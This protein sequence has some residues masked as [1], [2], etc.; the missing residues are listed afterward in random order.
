MEAAR[1]PLAE[2]MLRLTSDIDQNA[3]V[4]LADGRDRPDVIIVD[5]RYGLVTVDIEVHGADPTAREPFARL[6]RKIAEL[7]RS[8]PVVERFR[9]HRLVLFGGYHGKLISRSEA[10]RPNALSLVDLDS[11]SWLSWLEQRPPDIHD[12]DELRSALVPA[13]VFDIRARR[14]ASDPGLSARSQIRVTLDAEQA[15]AAT[16]PVEDVLMIS[17]PPGTGKTLVLAGRARF[18]ATEHPDWRIAVLCYNNALVPYLRQL[19]AGHTNI[20]VDTFGKFAHRLG[21]RISLDNEEQAKRDLERASAKGIARAVDAL[22]VDE[23]QDFFPAWIRFALA[24]MQAQRGGAVLVG[25]EE[26]ALYRD[27][28]EYSALVDRRVQRLRL[29]RSY[30]STRQILRATAAMHPQSGVAEHES[31]PEGQ[32]VDLIWAPTW[33]D[34]AAATAWEVRRMLDLGERGPQDIGILVTQKAGTLGRLRAGLDG[35]DVPYL[36]VSRDNASCF[37]PNSP[38]VKVMTVHSAKGYEF[39]VVILFGLEALPDPAGH[40]MEAARRGRVGFVGMTRARDQLLVTYT[41]DNP[42]VDRLRGCDDVRTWTWPDDY[43]V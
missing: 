21:H 28:V 41:R 10:P 30:R 27:T 4:L 22:L 2:M 8:T 5:Q 1:G 12:F 42:Y 13:L 9:P 36:V 35:V 26:Q 20:E 37:D 25:D 18:L 16:G 29:T 6:N 3:F 33:T 15:R 23:A 40:D 14:G 31:V 34:Q 43:E 39:G 17:G 32:S 24:T 38:E 19:V 7:R 11:C